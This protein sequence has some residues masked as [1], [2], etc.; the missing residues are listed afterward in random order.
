M[1]ITTGT[2][3]AQICLFLLAESRHLPARLLQT[4]AVIGSG[5]PP[6]ASTQPGS[7]SHTVIVLAVVMTATLLRP[8]RAA[9]EPSS[10]RCHDSGM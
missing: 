4:S 3:V 9:A 2:H 7:G 8:Y 5:R 6:I 1:H 10:V